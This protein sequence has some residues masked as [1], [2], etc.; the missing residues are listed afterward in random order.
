MRKFVL[1]LILTFIITGCGTSITHEQKTSADS[2]NV[3]K[4]L[5]KAEVTYIGLIDSHSI[6]VKKNDSYMALQINEDQFQQLETLKTNT[7]I[8][9]TYYINEATS[10]NILE[11]FFHN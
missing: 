9:I 10:Q 5:I 6:E 2:T 3:E 4:Q 1:P 7:P 8:N 11:V